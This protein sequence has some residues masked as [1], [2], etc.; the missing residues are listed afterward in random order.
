M[1]Q[2]AGWTAA[3]I[4]VQFIPYGMATCRLSVIRRLRGYSRIRRGNRTT[5][6]VGGCAAKRDHVLGRPMVAVP[7]AHHRGSHGGAWLAS[8]AYYARRQARHALIAGF[9]PHRSSAN[10]L[11]WKQ[12]MMAAEAARPAA[13]GQR[14]VFIRQATVSQSV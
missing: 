2:S 5:E 1:V 14:A 4:T 8:A 9:R 3:L 10:H 7:S 11:R 13:S 12:R 6:R